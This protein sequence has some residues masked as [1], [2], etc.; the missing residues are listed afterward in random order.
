MTE[1]TEMKGQKVFAV[2]VFVATFIIAT[3]SVYAGFARDYWLSAIFG[4]IVALVMGSIF[5]PKA[6]IVH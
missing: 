6:I 2:M 5:W 4:V 1:M 3:A